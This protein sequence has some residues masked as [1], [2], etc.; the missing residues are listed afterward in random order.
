M[1]LPD[2][3]MVVAV[4]SSNYGYRSFERDL[5]NQAWILSSEPAATHQFQRELAQIKRYTHPITARE[6]QGPAAPSWIVRWVASA[7]RSFF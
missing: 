6:L 3:S 2:G 1:T 4:G 7:L 5:E